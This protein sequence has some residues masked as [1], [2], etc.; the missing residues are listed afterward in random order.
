MQTDTST[1]TASSSHS[2]VGNVPDSSGRSKRPKD[3]RRGAPPEV[4]LSKALSWLLRHGALK[5]KLAIRPDGFVKVEDVLKSSRIKSI[6][7][8]PDG[9]KVSL[10]DVKE[11]VQSNEKKRFELREEEGEHWIRAVQG[12]SL[13]NVSCV[14][15]EM[16]RLT[17]DNLAILA[18]PHA[19]PLGSSNG[20]AADAQVPGYENP[21]PQVYVLHGTNK[22][23]WE[24]IKSSGGLS[25]M[26]RQHIHLAAGRPGSGVISGMRTSSPLILH[27]DLVSALAD[28]IP[29]L[30][31]SNGAVLT[32]GIEHQGQHGVLPLKYVAWVEQ[33][34]DGTQ[35]WKRDGD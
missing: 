23:A 24:L 7:L 27:V 11:V 10:E 8:P 4:V 18:A 17:L 32:P 25:R 9:R 19:S 31:A 34:K 28:G 21:G 26:K 15:V 30:I 6:Q 14:D 3:S 12:H 35:V 1:T 22:A 20:P 2:T 33:T 16:T 13:Q 29:F 5:E